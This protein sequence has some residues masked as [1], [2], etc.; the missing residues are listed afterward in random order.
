MTSRTRPIF[1]YATEIDPVMSTFGWK[2]IGL[3]YLAASLPLLGAFLPR[4]TPTLWGWLWAAWAIAAVTVALN[5]VHL[6]RMLESRGYV[7][8]AAGTVLVEVLLGTISCGLVNYAIGGQAGIYRPLVF[9]P[10]LLVAMIGNRFLIAITWA[11]AVL[12]VTWSTAAHDVLPSSVAAFVVSYG[13]TWGI[14]AIMVHL[15]ATTALHS[16]RQMLGLAD[17]AGIAA[18]ARGLDDGLEQML[19]VI[20]EWANATQAAAYRIGGGDGDPA[21]TAD[22]I[23]TAEP[24]ADHPVDGTPEL[25]ARWP[26]GGDRRRTPPDPEEL[27]EAARSRG[28]SYRSKRSV[29]VAA[30]GDHHQVAI[31]IEGAA[32]LRIDQLTDRFN[33]ERMTR[34]LEILVTRSRYIAQLEGLGLTDGLTGLP[35]RRSLTDRLVAAR[36]LAQRRSEALSVA[37]ID[38]DEFKSYNDAH[39]HLAGDDLLREFA[40]ALRGRLRGVDFVARYGGEE[41]CVVLPDTGSDDAQL[42]LEDFRSRLRGGVATGAV[43]FSAGIATWDGDETIESLVRRADAALYAAKAAGR[44]CSVIDG[45]T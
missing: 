34:Q 35:N 17:A 22:P 10:L 44:D 7:E 45:P 33:L 41:F 39:G 27:A 1:G 31:V 11:A 43:T 36:D 9:I 19:P 30:D 3:T 16:D 14:A 21:P 8:P 32:R 24:E 20:A 15:L 2:A 13:V 38:L 40:T 4:D 26:A 29:L 23:E 12:M 5:S 28:V 37:M 25:V 42:V 18:S 6:K